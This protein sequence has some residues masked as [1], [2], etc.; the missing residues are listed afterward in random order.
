MGLVKRLDYNDPLEQGMYTNTAKSSKY[1]RSIQIDFRKK[2]K[3]FICEVWA[4][5]IKHAI[6]IFFCLAAI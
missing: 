1:T 4:E 2:N 3:D 6:L 5:P